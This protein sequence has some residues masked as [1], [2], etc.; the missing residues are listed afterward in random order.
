MR[1]K[2]FNLA[3]LCKSIRANHKGTEQFTFA[4]N[5]L[6]FDCILDID[7]SPFEMIVGVLQLNF[8]FILK[9]EKGYETEMAYSDYVRLCQI[10][11]L[12]PSGDSFS[13]FA[14]LKFIDEHLPKQSRPEL[15]PIEKILPHRINQMSANDKAEGFIFCGWLPH[16]DKNNGNATPENLAKTRRLM[17]AAV[18]EYCQK[19]NISSRW[20]TDETQRR[21]LNFPWD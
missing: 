9:I 3:P 5:R 15:V 11:N 16:K 21:K 17:G 8:A 13:S 4:Y 7:A 20:T 2:F 10:L 19:N 6:S 18:S 12:R 1:F 14:F